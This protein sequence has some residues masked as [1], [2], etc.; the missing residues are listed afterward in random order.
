[1][2]NLF[3]SNRYQKKK[4]KTLVQNMFILIFNSILNTINHKQ[5][6]YHFS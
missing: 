3:S 2:Q 4:K 6:S 1:M 5:S